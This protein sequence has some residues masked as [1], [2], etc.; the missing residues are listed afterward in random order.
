MGVPATS[1]L[2]DLFW[3]ANAAGHWRRV[4]RGWVCDAAAG[5]RNTPVFKARAHI[6]HVAPHACLPNHESMSKKF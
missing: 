1:F 4:G 6:S 3:P 5:L 2:C